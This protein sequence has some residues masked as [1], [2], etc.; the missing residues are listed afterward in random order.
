ML[1]RVKQG[2]GDVDHLPHND[3]G[4]AMRFLT[5]L[6]QRPTFDQL[7]DQE[8]GLL[9]RGADI[10][11]GAMLGWSRAATVWASASSKSSCAADGITQACGILRAT[12]R[13]SFSS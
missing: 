8:Q 11:N 9:F 10:I 4:I 13:L 7:A 5:L 12:L 6:G 3:A 2:I 1:V